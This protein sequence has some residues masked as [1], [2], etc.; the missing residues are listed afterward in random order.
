MLNMR[1]MLCSYWFILL[2]RQTWQLNTKCV[3]NDII[4][5]WSRHVQHILSLLCQAR[6]SFLKWLF[7]FS[8][9]ACA[10][11][12][13]HYGANLWAMNNQFNTALD[14]AVRCRRSDLSRFLDN[15]AA[16]Q[17]IR[18]PKTA[19]KM[20][21]R[22]ARAADRRVRKHNH[23]D[24]MASPEMRSASGGDV[25]ADCGS[26]LSAR[27]VQFPQWR[28]RTIP[29]VTA[30]PSSLHMRAAAT[31][32]A[33]FTQSS[34]LAGKNDPSRLASDSS[35]KDIVNQESNHVLELIRSRSKKK[36]QSLPMRAGGDELSS[37]STSMAV[38]GR[39]TVEDGLAKVIP[40]SST[41]ISTV[42]DESSLYCH[43]AETVVS[44][45]EKCRNVPETD[46]NT[47]PHYATQDKVKSTETT[48]CQCGQCCIRSRAVICSCG[49]T[50]QHSSV[51][52]NPSACMSD[53]NYN[54]PLQAIYSEPYDSCTMSSRPPFNGN[55]S[56]EKRLAHHC[57]QPTIDLSHNYGKRTNANTT[58]T[59]W[60]LVDQLEKLLT[61]LGL[62]DYMDLFNN[63]RIDIESLA[64]LTD[65]DLRLLGL[66]LGPRKTLINYLRRSNECGT[67]DSTRLWVLEGESCFKFII[68]FS[69]HLSSQF[70]HADIWL[71]DAITDALQCSQQ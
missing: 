31:P 46:I 28:S 67:T 26:Y 59:R 34:H 25:S 20:R 30:P 61:K 64:L 6:R 51:I 48:Q 11:F 38:T 10:L 1:S 7:C 21:Q 60:H 12:L 17:E 45:S 53:I 27:C 9:S 56:V 42:S 24:Y 71:Y 33:V 65:N 35:D 44:K 37:V 39:R 66:P 29:T 49:K 5:C 50:C 16:K 36:R 41:P 2:W 58:S 47:H 57:H 3:N 40:K 18:D 13:V 52:L 69:E 4:N 55:S 22:A 54:N 70:Q 15:A 63:E 19:A 68:T 62:E 32:C 43:L 23:G 8:Q 14:L